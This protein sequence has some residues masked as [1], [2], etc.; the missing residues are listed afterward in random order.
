M[1]TTAARRGGW[2]PAAKRAW[3]AVQEIRLPVIRPLA[4]VVFHGRFVVRRLWNL[5]LKIVYR[6]PL[7]RYRCAPVGRRLSL[8]GEIPQIFGSGRIALG[9]DVVI[10]R[11]NSW[12]AGFHG[13]A[14]AEIVIGNRTHIGYQNI[15][16]AAN[17]IRIGDDVMFASNV[18]IFDNPSHPIEPAR[19]HLPFRLDETAPV[20]IGNNVWIGMNCFVMRG[21]TIGDNSVVAA[22]SVVTRSIP[23]N[24]VAAGNPAR[25]I[26]SLDDAPGTSVS[27]DA[28]PASESRG[29]NE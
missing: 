29:T 18:C 20:V 27:D 1:T 6:E 5:L 24:S 2:R 22:G 15:L 4:A 11:R 3:R 8:E 7:M 23:A 28:P 12:V 25:V 9:D 21:V 13:Y 14:G 10:G 17:S 16:A 19:R 26:K